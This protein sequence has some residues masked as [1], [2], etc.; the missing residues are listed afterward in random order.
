MINFSVKYPFY[1]LSSICLLFFLTAGIFFNNSYIDISEISYILITIFLSSSISKVTSRIAF[2]CGSLFF[3]LFFILFNLDKYFLL[4]AEIL[5]TI[6]TLLWTNK[7]NAKRIIFGIIFS[8][9]LLHLFYIQQTSVDFHQHDLSGIITYMTKITEHGLNWKEF[10]PWY[11][12]YAFH[13]P[14]HFV[15]LQYLYLFNK[16]IYI[17]S[18]LAYETLQYLSLFYVTATTILAV[19]IFRLFNLQKYTLY[20]LVVFVSFNPTLTLFSG[21]ISN[22]VAVLFWS[23]FSIY[24]LLLW[25]KTDITKYIILSSICFGLGTLSKLSILLYVPAIS[26]LFLC[27][28]FCSKNKEQTIKQLCIFL[29]IAIPL[30]LAWIIR[31]HILFD[32]QFYN[33]PDTS[34]QGQNFNSLSLQDRVLNFSMLFKPFINAP[35]IADPNIFLPIIKTELFG[36]WD[37]SITNKFIILPA[38]L[39]YFISTIIKTIV[40]LG[41]FYLIYR[42]NKCS[43]FNMFFVIIYFVTLGYLVKYALDYPYICSTDYRLFTSLL[44]SEAIVLGNIAKNKTTSIILLIVLS[45]YAFLSTIIYTAIV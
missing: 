6:I 21:Y 24:F 35:F 23:V 43:V 29:I 39:I 32:M 17:S 20:A 22:D 15:I 33:I 28:L 18:V 34:P 8:S 37:F 4:I 44:I 9:F 40:F 13:Q 25:Y 11:M 36:A 7:S 1:C 41:A 12:Y 14:L 2:I 10:N 30:S 27:K 42:K 38:T 19:R 45:F 16:S 5:Q 26:I 3:L 31:N